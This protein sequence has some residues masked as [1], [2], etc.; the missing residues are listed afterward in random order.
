MR[1]LDVTVLVHTVAQQRAT[2]ATLARP[3]NEEPKRV[4]K[5]VERLVTM[6]A[7]KLRPDG[8]ATYLHILP[9]KVSVLRKLADKDR[10]GT[11]KAYVMS[12]EARRNDDAKP[13]RTGTEILA[14]ARAMASKAPRTVMLLPTPPPKYWSML[15]RFALPTCQA[16]RAQDA[17]VQVVLPEAYLDASLGRE[18]AESAQ[19]LGAKVR[20]TAAIHSPMVLCTGTGAIH[21][22]ISGARFLYQDDDVDT[23]I[24]LADACLS[25]G[26]ASMETPPDQVMR[27]LAA[28]LTDAGAARR[29]GVSERQFR[30]YVS[31]LMNDLDAQSR[32][33]AGIEAGKS[34]NL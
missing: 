15:A 7:L 11:V 13:L 5:S 14:V 29:L 16:A 22:D 27:L 3:L 20:F 32:F 34:M 19:S 8:S 33:Q 1:N 30:R 24:P 6:G 25:E 12:C 9:G 31:D 28:G 18:F 10:S 23:L 4:A 2:L 26:R 21:I 17:H